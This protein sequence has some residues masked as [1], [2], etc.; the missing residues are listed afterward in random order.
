MDREALSMAK[1]KA[2]GT[3][4]HLWRS[5]DGGKKFECE[6]CNLIMGAKAKRPSGGCI[7]ED[8]LPKEPAIAKAVQGSAEECNVQLADV[9]IV[10]TEPAGEPAAATGAVTKIEQPKQASLLGLDEPA[11]ACPEPKTK[12]LDLNGAEVKEQ[13]TRNREVRRYV[14]FVTSKFHLR[15]TEDALAGHAL[16]DEIVLQQYVIRRMRPIDTKAVL[17]G[18]DFDQH[19]RLLVGA[20][21]G[22]IAVVEGSDGTEE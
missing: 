3:G 11:A 5:I 2:E 17:T 12:Q 9:S 8:E 21:A 14:D 10:P 22:K 19:T 7:V 18:R 1:K 4:T 20:L 13:V 15:T 16:K 6:K